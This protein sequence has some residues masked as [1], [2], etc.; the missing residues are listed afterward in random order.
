MARH[1]RFFVLFGHQFG[2]CLAPFRWW[3]LHG[4]SSRKAGGL[5]IGILEVVW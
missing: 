1:Y 4:Y 3:Y 2:V 5:R